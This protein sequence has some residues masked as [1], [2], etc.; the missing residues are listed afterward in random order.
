VE[1]RVFPVRGLVLLQNA[2]GKAH[3]APA[4]KRWTRYS[5]IVLKTPKIDLLARGD[6]FAVL[7]ELLEFAAREDMR[8]SLRTDCSTPPCDVHALGAGGLFDVFL[9][10]GDPEADRL[11]P[12]LDTC[13]EAGLPVRLQVQTP[14]RPSFDAEAFAD[15]VA[16]AGVVSANVTLWDPF[17]ERPPCRGEDDSRATVEAMNALA[18]A[19]DARDVESNLLRLPLCL[20]AEE[21]LVR[22]VNLPQFHVDHQQYAKAAY[23]MARHLRRHGP[24]VLDKVILSLLWRETLSFT[25][26]DERLLNWLLGSPARY[27]RLAFWRKLTKHWRL[28]RS[29]PKERAVPTR[30]QYERELARARKVEASTLGSQCAGCT[31]RRICDH[32]TPQFRRLLPGLAVA[33]QTEGDL[34]VSP[35]HFCAGQRKYYDPID[36]ARRDRDPQ[37]E[38]LA[39]AARIAMRKRQPDRRLTSHDYTVQNAHH[40]DMEAGIRWYSVQ[41]CEKL[42]SPLGDLTPPFT[43]SVTFAGGMADYIGFSLGRGAKLVCPMETFRHELT[44]HV[45]ADG[46]YVLLRD[47]A[48]VRPAEFEGAHYVPLRLADRLE[49]RISIWNIDGSIVT[50]LVR[51]WQWADAAVDLGEVKYSV[52][53][54]CTRFARRLQATLESL[55]HQRG[56][57]LRRVEI[58]VAYVPGLDAVDDVIDSMQ[59]AHPDLRI[60]R[61]TF[62]EDRTQSKGFLINESL[63]LASGAWIG[64]MDA[65]TLVPPDLF[66]RVEAVEAT[67]H[68]IAPDGRK[69]LPPEATAQVLLG[70]VRPWEDWDA[71]LKGP[72]EYRR[73]EAG[74]IPIGFCQFV[75]AAC[76]KKVGYT[77]LDHFEFADMWFGEAI[78]KAFG[79][80][81]WL[82]GAPVIHLDHGGSQ[83]YGTQTHR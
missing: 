61:A 60:L 27:I 46:R 18:A 20:V 8:L 59:L 56:F 78:R 51:L 49:P 39:A 9:C 34:V 10:P 1:E 15:L 52:V 21:N 7:P 54:V 43:L 30:E 42:S 63:G 19:L 48:P 37:A 35:L 81:T 31:W 71:L 67:S 65:D 44:L 3:R 12:W 57:D 76:L 38:E 17:L 66:A 6:R 47:E 26:Q 83:W 74:G 53:I 33:P 28:L 55:A 25:P 24:I 11:V 36:A 22:A 79:P 50:H 58:I 64:I 16:N 5:H 45:E 72:G 41:N 40:D 62:T 29:V 23:S 2:K 13:R 32:A 4:L 80:E 82:D 68:F 73:R 77:E 14:F 70:E 69:M 75:R